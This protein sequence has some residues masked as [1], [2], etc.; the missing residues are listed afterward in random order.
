[1]ALARALVEGAGKGK[2]A[3]DKRGDP[4]A[5][6]AGD[7]ASY[8]PALTADELKQRGTDVSPFGVAVSA[9][10]GSATI[11]ETMKNG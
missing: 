4:A 7:P 5:A 3:T 8:Q 9:V 6:E 2:D 11:L 1:V 10:S